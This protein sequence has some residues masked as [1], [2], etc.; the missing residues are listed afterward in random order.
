MDV[1]VLFPMAGRGVRFG[2][3]F[4]PFLRYGDELFIEA[5]VRPFRDH[6]AHIRRFVFVYLAEQEAAFAARAELARRFAGLPFEVVLLEQPTRGPAETIA[7]AAAA[8]G[9]TGRTLICDCDHALD[10]APLF[11][12]MAA[13]PDAACVIP[14]WSLAGESL[15][16]WSVAAIAPG[17]AVTAIAEKAMPVVAEG[18]PVDCRGVIGC[19]GFA[20]VADVARRALAGT[21]TNLSDVIA[22]YLREGRAVRAVSIDH[23]EFFGDPARLERALGLKPA[24]I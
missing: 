17:G 8:R 15:A 11:A 23:A 7:H 18:A 22:G 16:S 12:D 13:H 19:Y 5:A 2:G 1:T 24:Q 14:T 3:T 6:L 21:A 4:K 10:V 20:D 9:L